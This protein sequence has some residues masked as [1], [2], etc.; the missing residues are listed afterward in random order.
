MIDK[1]I[2][3]YESSK[4]FAIGYNTEDGDFHKIVTLKKKDGFDKE[5]ADK[6]LDQVR[7]LYSILKTLTP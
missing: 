4:I 6:V 2:K 5:M 7:K 1:E 3:M